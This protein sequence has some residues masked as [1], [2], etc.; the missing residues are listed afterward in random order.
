[1]NPALMRSERRFGAAGANKLIQAVRRATTVDRAEIAIDSLCPED[2][3]VGSGGS[4]HKGVNA[5]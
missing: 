5:W 1:M 3:E 2:N 4:L